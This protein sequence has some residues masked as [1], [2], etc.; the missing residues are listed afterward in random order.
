MLR[1]VSDNDKNLQQEIDALVG[2]P[3]PLLERIRMGGNGSPRFVI[4]EASS[5]ITGLLALDNNADYCNIEI[6]PGGIILTFRSLLESFGWIVPFP[7]LNIFKSG[8]I[9]SIYAGE[10]FVRLTSQN[11]SGTQ[12]EFIRRLLRIRAEAAGNYSP[13]D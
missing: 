7:K 5:T 1:N 8:N 3:Y 10:D 11:N 13:L 12:G 9:I 2:K 6:R 4:L